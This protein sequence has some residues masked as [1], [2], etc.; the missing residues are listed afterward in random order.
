MI[1]HDQL[2]SLLRYEPDTGNFYWINPHA[3]QQRWLGKVAGSTRCYPGKP[4]GAVKIMLL[5]KSYTAHRLAWF[6]VHHEWPKGMIDHINGDPLDNRIANLREATP[7]QNQFNKR[8]Q[9]RNRLGVKGVKHSNTPGKFVSYIRI[10]GRQ[11][12]LG[13]F[14]TVELAQAAYANAAIAAHGEFARFD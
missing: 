6:Y 2:I 4:V 7:R 8:V 11:T 14:S 5:R 13:T 12:Y 10:A 9:K 3:T 1:T